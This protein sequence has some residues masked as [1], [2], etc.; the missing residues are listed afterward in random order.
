MKNQKHE[1]IPGIFNKITKAIHL[2][3]NIFKFEWRF[4]KNGLSLSEEELEKIK[5]YPKENNFMHSLKNPP[6]ERRRDN[7][8]CE[9]KLEHPHD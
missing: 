7:D 9:T 5:H 8:Q 1:I 3:P 4:S 6:T 2:K